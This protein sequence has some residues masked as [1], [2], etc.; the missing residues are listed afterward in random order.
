MSLC[1]KDAY[2]ERQNNKIT[3]EA[4]LGHLIA[5]FR[6]VRHPEDS[7]TTLTGPSPDPFGGSIREMVLE[8][9]CPIMQ[10]KRS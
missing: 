10:G 5:H 9:D 1:F 8:T 4:Y 7:S 6:G 3:E 2:R